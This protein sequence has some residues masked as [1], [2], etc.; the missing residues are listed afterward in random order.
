MRTNKQRRIAA[1]AIVL[2]LGLGVTPALATDSGG[3][4][5]ESA[6]KTARFAPRNPRYRV[7]LGDELEIKFRFTSEFNQT[8]KVQ[9]DGFITLLDTGDLK[10]SD[11]NIEEIRNAIVKKYEGM[12]R[13]PVVTVTLKG[14]SAP[15][16]IVGG[17]VTKPG[18]LDLKGELTV[19]DAVAMAG[20]FTIGARSTE[21]MLFRRVSKDMVE[22]K[23]VNVKMVQNGRPEEDMALRPGDSIF[24][25]RSKIGKI[26]RFMSV[27]RAGL[28]FPIPTF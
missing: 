17:E 25:P 1:G 23:K 8:L 10:V 24:V 22:V 12:L 6:S 14:F 19:S 16:F 15:Y 18:R 11:L 13:N 3:A 26:N 21:V 28:Y 5:A 4:H 27:T 20:G 9:P 2:A 7:Q